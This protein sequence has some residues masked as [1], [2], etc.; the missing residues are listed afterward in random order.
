MTTFILRNINV[1]IK[2]TVQPNKIHVHE[3]Y[4]N[5]ETIHKPN[6]NNNIVPNDKFLDQQGI[7]YP[8]QTHICCWH[9]KHS[10]SSIPFG[11]PIKL[12][13]LQNINENIQIKHIYD[14]ITESLQD[15]NAN[16]TSKICEKCSNTFTTRTQSNVC[17]LCDTTNFIFVMIGYVCSFE[18]NL[19]YIREYKHNILFEH[20]EQLLNFLYF[21]CFNKKAKI[22]PAQDWRKLAPYSGDLS[23][24]IVAFRTKN[25]T[26]MIQLPFIYM[27]PCGVYHQ[28]YNV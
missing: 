14:S 20:S 3:E 22:V 15:L 4:K 11:I 9:C 17:T 2:H 28:A 26:H 7:V 18:C 1:A 27:T 24:D 8:Q 12:H 16:A 23:M 10:F 21:R 6:L 13:T 25:N 5:T 19:A